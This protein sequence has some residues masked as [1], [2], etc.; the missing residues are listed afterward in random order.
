MSIRARRE[1]LK[2][3][4]FKEKKLGRLLFCQDLTPEDDQFINYLNEE[5]QHLNFFYGIGAV[6]IGSALFNYTFFR[7]NSLMYQTSFVLISGLIGHLLVR[8]RINKRFEE[9][10]AP[11]FEKYAVK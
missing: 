3:V 2:K 8:R 9:R 4:G 1:Q 7:L 10:I 5:R 11:Y 6:G